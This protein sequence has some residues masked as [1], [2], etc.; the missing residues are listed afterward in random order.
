MSTTCFDGCIIDVVVVGLII[1]VSSGIQ[2]LLHRVLLQQLIFVKPFVV[3]DQ[4][5]TQTLVQPF[6]TNSIVPFVLYMLYVLNFIK[7]YWTIK[8]KNLN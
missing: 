5:S 2:S 4:A 3:F 7:I 6:I 1:V 8:N